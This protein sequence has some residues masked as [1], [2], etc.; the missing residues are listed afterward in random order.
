MTNEQKDKV[1]KELQ[2]IKEAQKKLAEVYMDL[3]DADEIQVYCKAH[4][5]VYYGILTYLD[6][7][8]GDLEK[9]L[10]RDH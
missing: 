6:V 3:E 8:N 10:L 1:Q 4:N 5:S 9:H 7:V 2:K